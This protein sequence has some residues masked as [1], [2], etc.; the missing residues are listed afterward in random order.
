MHND[1]VQD[2]D[3]DCGIFAIQTVA[4]WLENKARLCRNIMPASRIDWMKQFAQDKQMGRKGSSSCNIT[5]PAPEMALHKHR[6]RTTH[7]R[8]LTMKISSSCK[9][10]HPCPGCML[11]WSCDPYAR[12]H[13]QV[14]RFECYKLLYLSSTYNFLTL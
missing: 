7:P 12:V 1:Q 10:R 6:L 14:D 13:V 3:Y 11:H 5:E 9:S 2:N 4:S 8:V